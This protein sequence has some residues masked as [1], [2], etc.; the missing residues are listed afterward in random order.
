MQLRKSTAVSSFTVSIHRYI[1]RMGHGRF[2]KSTAWACFTISVFV[3]PTPSLADTSENLT[4][5]TCRI[6]LRDY[7]FGVALNSQVVGSSLAEV[8]RKVYLD[9]RKL[10]TDLDG[11][12]CENERLQIKAQASNGAVTS[13]TGTAV[14]TTTSTA[15]TTTTSR[16]GITLPEI[17]VPKISVP[18]ISN[19]RP[20]PRPSNVNYSVS[21][22]T[23]S[24]SEGFVWTVNITWDAPSNTNTSHQ[25]TFPNDEVL[26]VPAGTNSVSRQIQMKRYPG[27]FFSWIRIKAVIDG[28]WD[29]FESQHSPASFPTTTTTAR[30]RAVPLPTV[31]LPTVPSL[32]PSAALC[33][34]RPTTAGCESLNIP[35]TSTSSPTTTTSSTTTTVPETTTS[36]T[37]CV[38]DTYELGRLENAISPWHNGYT[39][40]RALFI[41]NGQ[42]DKARILDMGYQVAQRDYNTARESLLRCERAYWQ[43]PNFDLYSR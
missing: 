23:A 21:D 2:Q 30:V 26:V 42:I 29:S 9:N 43:I 40:V 17:S 18:R 7:P 3:G 6:I 20:T 33:K 28:E 34:L 8:R 16:I 1:F 11:L 19:P 12:I 35:A 32:K 31:V 36:T 38:P 22:V 41:Y 24:G 10:D 39:R 5:K 13:T 15:I 27:E 14:T 25:I 4:T 37:S